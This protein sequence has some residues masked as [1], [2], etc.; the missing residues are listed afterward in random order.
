MIHGGYVWFPA[1]GKGLDES[2]P[3]G[4]R[5][6]GEAIPLVDGARAVG[7][8]GQRIWIRGCVESMIVRAEEDVLLVVW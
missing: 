2:K 1:F 6:V 3:H 5:C 8:F 7:L 4:G